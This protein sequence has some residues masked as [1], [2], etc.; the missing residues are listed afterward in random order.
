MGKKLGARRAGRTLAF[1]VLYG[2]SFAKPGANQTLEWAFAENPAVLDEESDDAK[3]FARN[4]VEGVWKA[5]EEL[6]TFIHENSRHWKLS[7]IAKVELAILRL[8]LFE[9]LHC[10]DIPLKVAIN[11][12]I[13]LSK[14]FGDENSRNFINGI[15]DAVAKAVDSGRL[16]ISK[17]F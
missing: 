4:L 15:L 9:M 17:K 14:Q 13:E 8:A 6:D 12:A 7:R 5:Q 16:G 3:A 2:F 11:E 10:P 1:Q